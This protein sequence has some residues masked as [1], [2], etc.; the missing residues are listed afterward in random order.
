MSDNNPLKQLE[1][2]YRKS[3]VL[4]AIKH[5]L[6]RESQ[7]QPL[8]LV[9]EDLHWVDEESQEVLDNLVE[10]SRR[11]G[12]S[13]QQLPVNTKSVGAP[14]PITPDCGL[15]LSL[16]QMPMTSWRCCSETP[17]LCGL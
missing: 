2:P 6:V 7:R 5:L 15:I 4:A 12:Y 17:C 1:P 3:L 16:H 11:V 10:A 8:L 9:F 13:G 14:K